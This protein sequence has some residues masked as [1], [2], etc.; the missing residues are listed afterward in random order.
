VE[1]LV[2]KATGY[3]DDAVAR[4]IEWATVELYGIE[5]APRAG[6][7][8]AAAGTFGKRDRRSA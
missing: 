4:F 7:R 8:G 2:D 1:V 3:R 5:G 6:A